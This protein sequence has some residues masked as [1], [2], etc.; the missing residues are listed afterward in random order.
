[1]RIAY[2][3]F[4]VLFL[5]T[6]LAGCKDHDLGNN[7]VQQ[8]AL[9]LSSGQEAPPNNSPATGSA[10]VSYDRDAKKLTY[11]VTYSGLTGNP[12]MG[13]IHGSSPRGVNSGVIHHFMGIPQATSGTI[14]GSYD[15]APD[16][17]EDLLNGLFY[18]NIHTAAYP[19]GEIRGQIEFYD[20]DRNVVKKGLALT[21]QQ[22]VP[23]LSTPARGTADV[24]FNK[25]TKLLSYYITWNSLAGVPNGAHIHGTS[26]RGANSP[27]QHPFTDLIPKVTSGAFSNSVKVDGDKIKE[28][29]LLNGKYYFNIHNATYPA[30]EIRGQIEF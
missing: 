3:L 10:D 25:N 11:T 13:H 16:K 5:V 23:A 18:F 1:M 8:K 6:L 30:G 7:I 28:A 4:S 24:L 27:V 17:E 14:T 19:G 2:K 9:S 12:T 29:E 20:L 26:D 15:V 21:P 22:E